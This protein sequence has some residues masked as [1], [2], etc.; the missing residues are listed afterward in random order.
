MSVKHFLKKTVIC[1]FLS[2]LLVSLLISANSFADAYSAGIVAIKRGH[3]ET[4][5]RA[6]LPLAESG[7]AEAQNNVGHFYEQGLGVNQDY[8]QAISWYTK[9]GEQGLGAAQHNAGMLY[10]N[11]TGVDQDYS[12]AFTW[13]EKAAQQDVTEAQYMLGLMYHQGTEREEDYDRARE[14]F[15]KSAKMAYA[16][17]QFMYAYMLQSAQGGDAEPQKAMVWAALSELNGK[18]DAIAITSVAAMLMEDKEI[19]AV[20]GIVDQCLETNYAQCP[21]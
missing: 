18:T 13:F 7:K 20:Q 15:L 19:S 9:A 5:M 3:F 11:G 17:A 14:W 10:Y 2:C 16:N 1:R 21:E 12:Q 8:E 6:F 4:A